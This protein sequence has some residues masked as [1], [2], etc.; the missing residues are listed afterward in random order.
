LFEAEEKYA[1][2]ENMN[3]LYVALTRAKQVLLVSGNGELK[4]NSWYGRVAAVAGVTEN[5][6]H[7]SA[8]SRISTPSTAH[9]SKLNDAELSALQRPLNTGF[10]A[11]RYSAAQRHGTWLHALL[12]HLAPPHAVSDAASLQTRCAIPAESFPALL[13]QA[14]QLIALPN[15]QNFFDAK[16]YLHAHN[17]LAYVDAEGDLKRIDRLVEFETEVWV[18]D[19]KLSSSTDIAPHRA[20]MDSYRRAM[21]SIYPHKTVRCALVFGSGEWQ[22]MSDPI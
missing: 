22:E 5:P 15:L 19:Y 8:A 1:K 13:Q 4:E 17:E 18:L 11:A 21:Q 6:L 2:R 20:Q 3:L 14:Q 7:D 16:N 12:Q 9:S 10:R